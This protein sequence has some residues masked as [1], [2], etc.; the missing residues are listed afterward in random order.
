MG[1]GPS[2]ILD[3]LFETIGVVKIKGKEGEVYAGTCSNSE[4]WIL[5]ITSLKPK[6]ILFDTSNDK[7]VDPGEHVPFEECRI[8]EFIADNQGCFKCRYPN[9]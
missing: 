2:C 8:Y 1:I 7:C 3:H 9:G 6:V 4:L 5:K